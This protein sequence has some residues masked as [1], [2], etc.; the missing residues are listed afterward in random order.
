MVERTKKNNIMEKNLYCV[1]LLIADDGFSSAICNQECTI[2]DL[3]ILKR[4][5]ERGDISLI[6][7]IPYE[8]YTGGDVEE[9]DEYFIYYQYENNN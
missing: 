6:G 4:E 2:D 8:Y 5:D 3:E 1:A 7:W 9:E